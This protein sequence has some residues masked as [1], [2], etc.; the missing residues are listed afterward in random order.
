MNY[1]ELHAGMR[2]QF[3]HNASDN[4]QRVN[5][6]I[7]AISDEGVAMGVDVI[8]EGHKTI[9]F[10]RYQAEVDLVFRPVIDFTI[11]WQHHTGIRYDMICVANE[12][13]TKKGF[14]R[15]VVYRNSETGEVFARPVEEFIQKFIPVS[16]PMPIA[17]ESDEILDSQHAPV[18]VS[19]G[20]R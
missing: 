19:E 1:L 10:D 18:V 20:V 3:I 17:P 14:E 16:D 8:E 12:R 5:C 15:V 7:K 6:S 13:T 9:W 2:C 11:N 4:P